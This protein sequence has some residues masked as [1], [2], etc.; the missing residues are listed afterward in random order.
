MGHV[1]EQGL[2]ELFQSRLLEDEKSEATLQ[3][4]MR[5]VRAFFNY[6]GEGGTVA[7]EIVVRYKQHLIQKYAVVSANSMLAAVNRFCKEMGWFDC[8][9]KAFRVQR[10]A[11][12]PKE[13]ELSKTEYLRLLTAA[14]RRGNQRLY[15]LME[16]ICSTG[17]R[18]SE[19][20]FVT[21]E[22]L[23]MGKAIVSLK[24]KTR[25]V[26]LPAA[27]RRELKSYVKAAKIKTGSIFVTRSGKPM[28]RSNILHAM[29][30]LCK[31]AKVEKQKVF[32]HNLR[33]LFACLYYKMEKDISHL[34]DILGHSNINTTRIYT[35]VSGE[36]Q[37]KQIERMGLVLEAKDKIKLTA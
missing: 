21:V 5:D 34:A 8:V 4:Y 32:P 2:L 24:G 7:K 12:R 18:V 14:K 6:V 33:H 13:K 17:I 15:L 3:K 9:V 11:F 10:E 22:A 31:E 29:K 37:M 25:T 28:D 1:M 35:T 23:A 36:E 26:M 27:L 19:L 16:T 30:A 20:R